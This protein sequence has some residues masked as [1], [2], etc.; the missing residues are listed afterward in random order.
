MAVYT[1]IKKLYME[2]KTENQKPLQCPPGH[3]RQYSYDYLYKLVLAGDS[4]VG[5]TNLLSRFTRNELCPNSRQTIGVEFST[6]TVQVLCITF[7]QYLIIIL[8]AENYNVSMPYLVLRRL[9]VKQ[10]KLKYGILQDKN[11]FEQSPRRT[12]VVL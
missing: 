6:K 10:S 12:I 9:A 1:I 8:I 11:D 5:K 4:G 7:L 3:Q 2:G